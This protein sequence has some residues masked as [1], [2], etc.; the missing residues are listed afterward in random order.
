MM[1]DILVEADYEPLDDA[2][3]GL[4][5]RTTHALLEIANELVVL[6]KEVRSYTW[7]KRV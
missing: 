6:I 3:K 5:E 7:D 4:L 2:F 1:H